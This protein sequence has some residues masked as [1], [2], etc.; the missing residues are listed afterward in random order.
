[1]Q[2]DKICLNEGVGCQVDRS[3]ALIDQFEPRGEFLIEHIRDG[4]VINELRL[5]N[6]VVNEGKNLLLGTAFHADTQITTWYIGLMDNAS[7]TANPGTDSMASHAGWLEWGLAGGTAGYSETVR[8]TWG[9]GAASSQSITNGTPATF[10]INASGTLKGCFVCTSNTKG[11]TSG[12]LWSTLAFGSTVAVT[13]GDSIK[14]TY[15]LSC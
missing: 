9:V 8:Q 11:G 6:T 10:S 7:Y 1:M 12:T 14:V 3:R 4:K 13:N 15:V 5:K 2:G